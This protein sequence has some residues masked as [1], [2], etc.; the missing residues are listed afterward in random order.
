[1]AQ[2][3]KFGNGTWATKKGSTLAYNDEDNNFKPLP[4]SFERNSIATRVNKEGLIEVVG[5]DIPRID[6]TDSSEGALLL[7]NSSTNLI[8]YSEDFSNAAWT[9]NNSSVTSGFTSPDG[10]TNAFKLIEDTSSTTEHRVYV[11]MTSSVSTYSIRA[12]VGERSWIYIVAGGLGAYFDLENGIIGT[13]NTNANIKALSNGWYECSILTAVL[14]GST[15]NIM[16]AKGN[17]LEVYTGDG[18]SGVYIYGAMLESN[19]FSTSYIPT[20]GSTVQRAAET[21]NESGNSEVFND[22][23]GVLFADMAALSNDLTNRFISL[24]DGSNDNRVLFGYRASSN[25]VFAR[26]EGNNSASVDLTNVVSDT[27]IVI[28][29]AIYYDSSFNYK[30]YLNGFL[31]DNAIGT[32]SIIG[33]DRFDFTNAAGTENFYGKT[34]EIAYYDTALTDEELEYMTSYR[35]LNEMVTELNLNAL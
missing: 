6:Y 29:L 34:K 30:M 32:D 15:A 14:N 3:Y 19:S 16:I 22:S 13:S 23:Q 5:N 25:Q 21:C 11:S 17:G 10:T 8:T 2:T 35:S 9:K 27:E 26:I 4:F 33:L 18:T 28:K 12:K 24:T 7:E 20:S 31:V 1:M